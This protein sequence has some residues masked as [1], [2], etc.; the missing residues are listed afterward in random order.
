MNKIATNIL[1]LFCFIAS[2]VW[3]QNINLKVVGD[4]VQELL[5]DITE[6]N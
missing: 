3:S 6:V 2:T 5:V 4:D 1:L